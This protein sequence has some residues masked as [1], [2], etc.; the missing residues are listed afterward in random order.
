MA[1]RVLLVD[2]AGVCVSR[3][4]D[5]GVRSELRMKITAQEEAEAGDVSSRREWAE[6]CR[7]PMERSLESGHFSGGA[8]KP[9]AS[10]ACM[11]SEWLINL[12]SN[13]TLRSGPSI[14]T[15]Q[16]EI[17]FLADEDALVRR[18]SP[19][20]Q[21]L[22]LELWS[23]AS[24]LPPLP[25]FQALTAGTAAATTDHH[26]RDCNAKDTRLRVN[27]QGCC[28]DFPDPTHFV[29]PPPGPISNID[30]PLPACWDRPPLSLLFSASL[31]RIGNFLLVNAL[32]F[33]PHLSRASLSQEFLHL[34]AASLKQSVELTKLG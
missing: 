30:G 24:A 11:W 23:P 31:C 22:G 32:L 7:W 29:S 25:R 6:G 8:R 19:A 34:R 14:E 33:G 4:Q 1:R 28:R 10:E 3:R 12:L 17:R 21:T 13:S 27:F 18:C 2:G 5:Q 9:Q 20:P 26:R 16:L 15:D